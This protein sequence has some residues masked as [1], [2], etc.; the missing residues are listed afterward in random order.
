MNGLACALSALLAWQG[1]TPAATAATGPECDLLDN[2]CK[3][4][5]F[6]RKAARAAT[7]AQRAVYLHVAYRSHFAVFEK[8]GD[9]RELCA[10]R[11][12]F[13]ASLAVEGQP[14]GQLAEFERRR[15]ELESNE[16]EHRAH[17][18]STAKRRARIP[19]LLAS[20][21]APQEPPG[22]AIPIGV[23]LLHAPR[24]VEE[25]AVDLMPVSSGRPSATSVR[26]TLETTTVSS[27]EQRPAPLPSPKPGPGRPLVI[28]G[29][30]VLGFGVSLAGVAGWAGGTALAAHREGVKLH[31]AVDG[32]PDN[33]AVTRD[34]GLERQY[35]TLRPVAIG[36]A[37][38]G[39][40]AVLAGA[41]MV[42]IG[43]RRLAWTPSGVAVLPA[44]GGLFI[45]ARF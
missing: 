17:C 28:A 9:I 44:P 39:G 20:R 22:A 15:G 3:A 42:A 13:D 45:H 35:L 14:A 19:A 40:V 12:L 8:T 41:V 27:N 31:A 29:S 16:R 11:R 38:A 10:A 2:R 37:V 23:G 34:A 24:S 33:A 32:R 6:E 4:D 30:V 18:G 25:P 7:P 1:A 43:V 5:L 21:P 36:T 26:P